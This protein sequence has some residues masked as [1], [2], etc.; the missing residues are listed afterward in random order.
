VEN[1]TRLGGWVGKLH[2][3]SDL[4]QR[5]WCSGSVD[6]PVRLYFIR[7][8]RS[9][10]G[11]EWM[12]VTFGYGAA[13]PVIEPLTEPQ[14]PAPS[15]DSPAEVLPPCNIN[16]RPLILGNDDIQS[17]P[18]KRKRTTSRRKRCLLRDE[19]GKFIRKS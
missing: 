3:L 8:E 5:G 14:I 18:T 6:A 1:E 12:D 10:Q 19:N 15:R 16:K 7:D 2:R 9:R 11:T 4:K 17:T 13:L